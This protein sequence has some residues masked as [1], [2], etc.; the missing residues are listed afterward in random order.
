MKRKILLLG[1][2]VCVMS[3]AGVEKS[4]VINSSCGKPS[5][6]SPKPEINK[7]MPC[8]VPVKIRTSKITD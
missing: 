6:M 4:N 7:T 1:L 2:I 8:P 3:C 5:P